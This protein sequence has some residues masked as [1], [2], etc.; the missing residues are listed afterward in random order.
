MAREPA[1]LQSDGATTNGPVSAVRRGRH[2]T[3]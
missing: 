3:T 2:A 1:R